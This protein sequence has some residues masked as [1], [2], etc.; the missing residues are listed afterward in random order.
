MGVYEVKDEQMQIEPDGML[1]PKVVSD[2]QFLQWC[3]R[4]ESA[5]HA[6]AFLSLQLQH[7]GTVRRNF[8]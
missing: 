3:H 8:V 6:V 4:Q 2:G 1:V 7:R 5:C